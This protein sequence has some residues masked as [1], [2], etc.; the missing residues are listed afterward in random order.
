MLRAVSP[1]I[2]EGT[3]FFIRKETPNK[4]I[5]NTVG[6]NPAS[7]SSAFSLSGPTIKNSSFCKD[8]T[9]APLL[10]HLLGAT[11][12]FAIPTSF[13]SLANKLS[14]FPGASSASDSC[15]PA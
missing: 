5:Q 13:A 9:T 7:D 2:W 4:K 3:A 10:A 11:W 8:L 14:I 12:N 6:G 15:L 1:T